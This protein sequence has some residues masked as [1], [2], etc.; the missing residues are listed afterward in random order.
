MKITPIEISNKR[1]QKKILGYDDAYVD[2][3]LK[4][5]GQQFEQVLIEKNALKEALREKE[6]KLA[7]YKDRE[8]TLQNTIQ[9][10][11]LMAERMREDSEREAKLI[12]QDAEQRA[13]MM[14]RD[15]KENLK[16]MYQEIA[17]LKRIRMQFESGFKAL[18]NAHLSLIED[19]QKIFETQ[20]NHILKRHDF[21]LARATLADLN[22]ENL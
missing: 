18:I 4:E 11:S 22:Q 7:E 19:S 16:K 5:L 8:Q 17:D 13:Q 14:V 1:F 9:T 6:L 3:F 21:A 12:T 2:Q 10:A 20:E 15:A